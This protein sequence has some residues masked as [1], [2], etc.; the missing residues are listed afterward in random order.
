M[1]EDRRITLDDPCILVSH[2]FQRIIP[3]SYTGKLQCAP[4]WPPSMLREDN[5]LHPI[6]SSLE[7]LTCFEDKKEK[8]LDSTVTGYEIYAFHFM[9]KSKY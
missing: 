2:D 1:R 9:P 5:Q 8:V 6:D 3:I 7:F 4:D